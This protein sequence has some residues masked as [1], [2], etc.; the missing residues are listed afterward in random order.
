MKST[1]RFFRGLKGKGRERRKGRGG[2]E[3]SKGSVRKGGER[4]MANPLNI[5]PGYGPVNR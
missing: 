1:C 2:N 3:G 4:G 5:N